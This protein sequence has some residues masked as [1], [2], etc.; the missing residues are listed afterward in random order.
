MGQLH[1]P[2]PPPNEN[3]LISKNQIHSQHNGSPW[4]IP[5]KRKAY[6]NKQNNSILTHTNNTHTSFLLRKITTTKVS[7]HLNYQDTIIIIPLHTIPIQQ[8]YHHTSITPNNVHY[9]KIT[10]T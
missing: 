7:I 2:P 8:I 4:Q 6:I 9:M 1:Q 5:K 10:P 3:K